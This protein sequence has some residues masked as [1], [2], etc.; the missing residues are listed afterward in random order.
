[1][2]A[3]EAY[4][5]YRKFAFIYRIIGKKNS[6]PVHAFNSPNDIVSFK[7]SV[8]KHLSRHSVTDQKDVVPQFAHESSVTL[9]NSQKEDNMLDHNIKNSYSWFE[10]SSA[11]CGGIL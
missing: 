11:L 6:L 5:L 7:R 10:D 8:K 3:G 4:Q 2:Y 9:N 1:M